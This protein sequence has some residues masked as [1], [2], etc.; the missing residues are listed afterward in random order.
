M[1]VRFTEAMFIP[2]RYMVTLLILCLFA[3][4]PLQAQQESEGNSDTVRQMAMLEE[5]AASVEMD[6]EH[7]LRGAMAVLGPRGRELDPGVELYARALIADA[8][9]AQGQYELALD[10]ARQWEAAA[11]NFQDR[12]QQAMAL[13]SQGI[14]RWYLGQEA[15]SLTAYRTG[16]A[17]VDGRNEPDTEADILNN[18]GLLYYEMGDL[19]KALDNFLSALRLSDETRN[20][21]GMGHTLNSLGLVYRELGQLDVAMDHLNRAYTIHSR[22]GNRR[23]MSDAL[24]NMG[25]I[26]QQQG[27]ADLA[28]RY[29]E[30]SMELE[31]ELGNGSGVAEGLSNMGEASAILQEMDEAVSYFNRAATEYEALGDLVGEA[32]VLINL[33]RLYRRDGQLD[34]AFEIGSRAMTLNADIS[35]RSLKLRIFAELA[36]IHAVRNEY[37][38]AYQMLAAY[39]SLAGQV[40][41]ERAGR[42]T[43]ELEDKL[44]LREMDRE[45]SS[46]QQEQDHQD[47]LIR[48]GVS[49][50]LLLLTMI[51][52]LVLGYRGKARANRLMHKANKELRAARDELHRLARIDPLTGLYNRRAMTERLSQERIR[53]ERTGRTFSLVLGDVDHFK[54]V[55]DRF[56]HGGGDDVLTGVAR[57][58]KETLRQQD[59]V[60]RWG[61]E[62]FLLLLPETS[63]EGAKVVAEKIRITLEEM[64]FPL[65]GQKVGVT[66]TFGVTLFDGSSIGE[67]L[68][69][70]DAALYE[71]KKS[72]RN[73]VIVSGEDS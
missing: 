37:A 28:I 44:K 47:S 27:R 36:E 41:M 7:V 13:N 35:D 53:Y 14:S 6:P 20:P 69:R 26:Y 61:G 40:Q 24:N 57:V 33:A 32:S 63:L 16:L 71:G 21:S 18:L 52:L 8:Y 67:A 45:I 48:M 62:E 50:L 3:G 23:G 64:T 39:M 29:Y 11:S 17:L 9:Q 49:A 43:A 38:E 70:A 34:R 60:A 12:V 25:V 55:N 65:G 56:G 5:L 22:L 59:A 72:G 19:D 51:L 2:V 46:L 1:V 42:R 68:R 31:K 73:C 10:A 4:V 66:I 58:F 15:E 54:H 30:Q